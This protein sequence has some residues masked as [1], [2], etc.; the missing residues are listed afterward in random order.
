MAKVIKYYFFL[1]LILL[2]YQ[3]SAYQDYNIL[4]ADVTGRAVILDNNIEKARR[5]ALE[6]AL[7]LS[8]IHI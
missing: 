2:P 8:L 7:Y 3:V 4:K 1:L 5:L 6:D